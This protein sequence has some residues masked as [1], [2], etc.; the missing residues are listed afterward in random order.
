MTLA[1]L[2]WVIFA[3]LPLPPPVVLIHGIL[4]TPGSLETWRAALLTTRDVFVPPVAGPFGWTMNMSRQCEQLA[5][6]INDWTADVPEVDLVGFSQGGLLGRCVVEERALSAKVRKLVT[7]AT[8]HGGLYYELCPGCTPP[9]YTV[10]PFDIER[11][12]KNNKFLAPLNNQGPM[13]STRRADALARLSLFAMAWSKTDGL[14]NPPETA[15]FGSFCPVD[16]RSKSLPLRVCGLNQTAAY[17]ALA[18]KNV[19]MRTARFDCTHAEIT[20]P[21]CINRQGGLLEI[22]SS[23]LD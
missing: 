22:V 17:R 7:V 23:W 8:P 4:G 10:D 11:F 12:E 15:A 3:A 2:N 18:L 14:L 9:A 5:Q 20:A 16:S 21:D 13:S 1:V 19:V 6:E